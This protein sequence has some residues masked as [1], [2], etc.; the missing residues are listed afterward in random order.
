MILDIAQI[1]ISILLITTILLQQRG[2][3][4]SSALGGSGGVYYQKR[5]MEK[6]LYRAT[7]ALAT[8]FVIT[9]FLNL[10]K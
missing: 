7:I 2:S 8:L 10:L 3:G 9:A 1:I 5:G 6:I 4:L